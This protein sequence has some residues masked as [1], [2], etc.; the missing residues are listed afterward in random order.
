MDSTNGTS[1]PF[2]A[3]TTGDQAGL[4]KGIGVSLAVASGTNMN[5]RQLK[6]L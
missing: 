3:D 4:Y 6:T 1:N 2:A 5:R